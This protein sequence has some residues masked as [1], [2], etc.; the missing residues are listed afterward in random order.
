MTDASKVKSGRPS[1]AK[2]ACNGSSGSPS[3]KNGRHL[4]GRELKMIDSQQGY[5]VAA[6]GLCQIKDSPGSQGL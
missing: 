1:K 2:L 4:I 3:R 5:L 6:A